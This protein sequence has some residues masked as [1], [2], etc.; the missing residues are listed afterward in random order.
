MA[1]TRKN[2]VTDTAV[3]DKFIQGVKLLKQETSGR[4]TT[5]FGI[6]GPKQ[7]VSTYDLF[8]VWHHRAMMTL[9]PPGNSAG[10]NA[11]HRGPVFCPWHRVMLLLLEQNLQRVLSDSTFGLPYWDWSADGDLPVSQ[12]PTAPIWTTSYLGGEGNPV[13][14][15]PFAF[16]TT[17][18]TSWRVR[19]AGNVSGNLISVNRGLRRTFAPS[20]FPSL[21]KT[22]HVKN[23][24]LLN[25]YDSSPWDAG[26][27]GFRNRLEGWASEP[28]FAPPWLHNLVHVWIGGD[29]APSTSPND[30]VFYLNHCNVD[31]V[32]EKWLR[33][34]GR[35]YV[36][37]MT[38]STSLKGHR[39]DDPIVSPLGSNAT[40]RQVLDVSTVY[41]YDTLP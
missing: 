13:S 19:I 40:P 33:T 29:M 30:P 24:L 17:D 9:T 15:G 37:N 35:V 20:S 7:P 38:A 25:P 5:D 31:R 18:P 4:T 34:H 8:V 11:A 26:T 21:P 28:T 22:S 6:S 32:W 23:A 3:R 16:H 12:Q 36:P 10:R 41:S 39:I 1:V 14:T 27:S 2:I